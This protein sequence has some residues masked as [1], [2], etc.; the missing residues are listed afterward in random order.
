M[1]LFYDSVKKLSVEA[2]AIEE[3]FAEEQAN[4]A[5]LIELSARGEKSETSIDLPI[6]PTIKKKIIEW[7]EDEGFVVVETLDGKFIKSELIVSWRK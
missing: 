5:K 4:I 3:R 2:Q 1:G 6:N 7:L